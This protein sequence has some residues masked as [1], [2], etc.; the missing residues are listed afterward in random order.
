MGGGDGRRDSLCASPRGPVIAVARPPMLGH[1]MAMRFQAL[2][3]VAG[4]GLGCGGSALLENDAQ[5]GPDDGASVP[6]SDGTTDRS[7]FA[8]NDATTDHD[9][10]VQSN[11][12][13]GGTASGPDGESVG[14]PCG[15]LTCPDGCCL[16]GGD[17]FVPSAS[18]TSFAN[19]PCG[20]SGEVCAACPSGETCL[21]GGCERDLQQTCTS[22]NCAGCCFFA[23]G[24]GGASTPSTQCYD[25]SHDN[26]CGNGGGQCQRCTPATNGGHCVAES[27]GGGH[28]EDV[29]Q[30]NSTNCAGCCSGDICAEG[31]QDVACGGNGVACQNCAGDGGICTRFVSGDGSADLVCGYNCPIYG[32]GCTSYCSSPSDCFSPG[33]GQ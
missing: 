7:S 18:D 5:P 23:V 32:V 27:T 10:T 24:S 8:G 25:G 2:F 13:G 20:S 30:C 1:A 16:D 11:L 4:L 33:N 14:G 15:P 3:A 19:I 22:A 17:C 31:S 6:G 9:L 21:G 28:C 29:G 12:D 26:F